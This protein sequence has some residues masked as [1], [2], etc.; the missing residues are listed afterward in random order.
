MNSGAAGRIEP[1][2]DMYVML[3]AANSSVDLLDHQDSGAWM[4]LCVV[5][6]VN[7]RLTVLQRGVL[8]LWEP[9][10]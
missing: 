10:R 3:I 6:L 4:I 5:L 9:R 2:K 8:F 7:V 1:S